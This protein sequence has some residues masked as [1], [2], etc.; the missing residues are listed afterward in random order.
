MLKM[1]KINKRGN[2]EWE[3]IA[4]WLIALVI[5]FVLIVL[6]GMF[7]DKLYAVFESLKSVFGNG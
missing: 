5:L 1:R 4:K 3:T 6:V 2:I 7:K